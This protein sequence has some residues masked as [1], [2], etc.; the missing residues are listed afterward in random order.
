MLIVQNVVDN[1]WRSRRGEKP[2]LKAFVVE[3]LKPIFRM[4]I[5]CG[6]ID[7]WIESYT[8]RVVRRT[9]N[10]PPPRPAA[11]LTA[12]EV[13]ERLG[14]TRKKAYRLVYVTGEIP[15]Q[16]FSQVEYN[17]W[18]F[19]LRCVNGEALEEWIKDNRK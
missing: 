7:E 14:M 17:K 12:A 6:S 16:E 15:S 13:A 2:P 10:P 4:G 3:D 18:E 1:V 9:T 19:P 8:P 11:C 5:T